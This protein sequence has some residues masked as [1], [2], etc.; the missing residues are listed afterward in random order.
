MT[1]KKYLF[2]TKYEA[3]SK[4]SNYQV[5]AFFKHLIE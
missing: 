5:L 1:L 2:S 4:E 3:H